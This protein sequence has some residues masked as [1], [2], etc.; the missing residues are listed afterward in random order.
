[1]RVVFAFK[2]TSFC[3]GQK[4]SISVKDDFYSTTAI[5]KR[6]QRINAIL[7]LNR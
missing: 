1:M 4:C 3:C 7:R 5:V 6:W 2:K